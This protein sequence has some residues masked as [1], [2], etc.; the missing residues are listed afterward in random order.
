[1][2]K[3]QAIPSPWNYLPF[4]YI[5]TPCYLKNVPGF[6]MFKVLSAWKTKQKMLNVVWLA[7]LHALIRRPID[8]EKKSGF[9]NCCVKSSEFLPFLP[10]YRLKKDNCCAQTKLAEH[11]KAS[12]YCSETYLISVLHGLLHNVNVWIIFWP[13]SYPSI[14]SIV[15]ENKE[16]MSK[17]QTQRCTS[18]TLQSEVR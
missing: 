10:C 17:L 18:K 14:L 2:A 12:V 16:F 5:H 7:C 9:R 4:Y 3:Y 6:E 1:M 11:H 13:D 15:M 8:V